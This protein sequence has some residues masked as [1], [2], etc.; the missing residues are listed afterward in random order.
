[1]QP[2][3]LEYPARQKQLQEMGTGKDVNDKPVNLGDFKG[4]SQ[5]S[6]DGQLR[7]RNCTPLSSK[8][9]RSRTD[10]TT[11]PPYLMIRAALVSAL[12]L[13]IT[14]HTAFAG[15]QSA[16]GTEGGMRRLSPAAFVQLPIPI[17]KALQE[18]ACTIPQS[19]ADPEPHNVVRGEL[20]RQGQ[21]DVA[22]LCSRD[23]DSSILV[24]WN[25]SVSSVTEI[26][27]VSDATFLQA[28]GGGNVGYSRQITVVEREFIVDHYRAYG[29]PEPPSI[30]HQGINDAFVEKASIVHYYH[31]GRWLELTGAD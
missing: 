28:I 10:K 27:K 11:I 17:V 7:Y 22:V 5:R 20:R 25:S 15:Q 8:N 30:D 3:C 6:L 16:H 9:Y 19:F 29:G 26:A 21:T 4:K 2:P 23:G 18:R 1:M 31:E 12:S 14:A 13:M 24:F